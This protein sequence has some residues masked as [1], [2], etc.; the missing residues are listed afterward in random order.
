VDRSGLQP[1]S[2]RPALKVDRQ[3]VLVQGAAPFLGP[4]K[5]TASY[6]SVPLPRVVVE[7]LSTHLAGFPAVE[8]EILCRDTG[9]KTW[10]E[11][12][13]LV[14]TDDYGRPIRRTA[15]SP[16]WRRAVRAAGAPKDTTFHD[17]RHY[18]ASLLIRHGESVKVVQK[19][20]GHA[21]AAET[22]DTYSH[23]WPDSEDR[24]RQ[25]I[26]DVLG[27]KPESTMAR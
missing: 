24:T 7:A 6:R 11:I 4:P 25:A 15:F 20:L 14:F 12:V 3:L 8:Q 5:T 22:L 2:A 26:D 18:Y 21:T 10:P 27:A 23:L 16:I 19:R 13:A 9:G 17:L 1:P